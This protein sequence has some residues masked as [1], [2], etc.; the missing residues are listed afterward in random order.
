MKKILLL[1]ALLMGFVCMFGQSTSPKDLQFYLNSAPFKMPAITVP[2]FSNKSFNIKDYGAVSDGQTLNTQAIAKAI[3]AC[4]KAGGGRVVVPAGSWL[5]G[6]IELKSNINLHVERGGLV[7]FTTDLTQYPIIKASSTSSNYTPASPI[8]GYDLKNIAITGDGIIDGNGQAWRPVKKSKVT[9]SEW[10]DLVAGGGVVGKGDIWWPSNEAMEGENYL[11]QLKKDK[12]KATEADYLPARTFLRPY[13]VL[14]SNCQNV[15]IEGI[16]LRNSP[17]FVFYPNHC[18]NLV[19]RKASI[20]NEWN[21]QN[22]DGIDISACKNVAIYQNT[23]SVGDDG[24]CMKSS[25][26]KSDSPNDFQLENIVIADNT[27]YRAH[28]GF[29]IGSNTD[30]NMRNIWVNNCTFVGTDIGLRIKSN[31]GRGGLVK[32]IF[33]KDIFM[34]QILDAAILFDTYYEDVPAGATADSVRTT[35][36]DKTPN[37]RDFTISNVY[38]NGAKTAIAITGLPEMPV[39]HITFNNVVISANTGVQSTDASDITFNNVNIITAKSP[40]YNLTNS[41]N[42]TIN[43]VTPGNA[44]TFIALNGKSSKVAIGGKN[45][46]AVKSAIQLNDGITASEVVVK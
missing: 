20:L 41:K 6:P 29:V 16:T 23:V 15:L 22:G 1:P 34:S 44:K 5:T 31:A 18:T 36:R 21:A 19:V 25:G 33:I 45:A 32:D 40:V 43:G 14:L 10:K 24:I 8:Y 26:G 38:C 9:A 39:N 17:K 35:L 46:Q 37:F 12:P 4:A 3:D 27:V 2:T 13:M 28:G 7:L 42:F 30:G 11:K